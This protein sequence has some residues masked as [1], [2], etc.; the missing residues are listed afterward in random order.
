MDAAER[1]QD[2]MIAALGSIAAWKVGAAARS[3]REQM[4]LPR[5]FV[6][7]LPEYRVFQS[8]AVVR[9]PWEV[10]VGVE[11][12]YAYRFAH[13][14]PAR[15]QPCA[16]ETLTS[17]IGSVHAAFEIPASR[18]SGIGAHGGF[19]LVADNG[20]AGWLVVGEGKTVQDWRSL[21]DAPVDLWVAGER[22]ASGSA[23]GIDGMPL[24]VVLDFVHILH[25]RG[26]GIRAG[27]YVVTGS[28]TGYEQIPLDTSVRADFS[29]L[30][31][32]SAVFTAHV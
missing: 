12:E 15:P 25:R 10:T 3:G 2:E 30:G 17:A 29:A 6:G 13:D 28:C 14:L 18:F 26:Y 23:A 24:D 1:V 7:A 11:S 5:M 22:R 16:M 4:G 31:Q 20:S 21:V 9:G 32:V 19:A 8:G 27:Q